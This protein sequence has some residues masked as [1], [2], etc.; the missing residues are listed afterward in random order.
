MPGVTAPYSSGVSVLG[1]FVA[2]T[3]HAARQQTSPLSRRPASLRK[4]KLCIATIIS[5]P[6]GGGLPLLETQHS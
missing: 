2:S 6:S 1:K 3:T 5:S 4:P